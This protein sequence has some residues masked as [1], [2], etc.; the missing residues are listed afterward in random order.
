MNQIPSLDQ[1]SLLDSVEHVVD[2]NAKLGRSAMTN[3]FAVKI[4]V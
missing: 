1:A 4:P 2:R 3:M